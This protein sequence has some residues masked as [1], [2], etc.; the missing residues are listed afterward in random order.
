MQVSKK[1]NS[2]M[3][4]VPVSSSSPHRGDRNPAHAFDQDVTD[5][6]NVSSATSHLLPPSPPSSPSSRSSLLLKLMMRLQSCEDDVSKV[7]TLCTESNTK[8][9]QR[10]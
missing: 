2:T 4:N 9:L 1:V 10:Q 5:F 8:L 6:L 7:A 3:A